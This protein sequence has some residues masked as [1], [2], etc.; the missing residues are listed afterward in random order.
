M[1]VK[2]LC[3][4]DA[5]N[6]IHRAY[7]ALPELTNSSGVPTNATLGFV[8]MLRKLL[9]EEKPDYCGVVFDPPGPTVRH[10]EYEGYKA[11]RSE[12]PDDLRAQIPWIRRIIEAM[13]IPIL[14][15]PSYEADDVIFESFSK[16][17]SSVNFILSGKVRV[18]VYESELAFRRYQ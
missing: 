16:E 5:L 11:S 17:D 1:A 14:E 8:T 2:K 13:Y 15:L 6:Q 9:A 12:T 3:L 7:H 4:I 10:E 18:E